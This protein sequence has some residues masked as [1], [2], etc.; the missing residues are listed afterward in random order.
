MHWVFVA[1][2]GLSLVVH[3][4]SL[5]LSRGRTQSSALEGGLLI[6]GLPG[7]SLTPVS[8]E[9]CLPSDYYSPSLTVLWLSVSHT[10]YS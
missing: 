7:K 4:A 8:A 10:D 2:C 5:P 6:I 1:A 9:R 3:Q